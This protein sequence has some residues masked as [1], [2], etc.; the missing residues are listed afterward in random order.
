METTWSLEL[1]QSLDQ[2]L[3]SALQEAEEYA[4]AKFELLAS[5]Q[6]FFIPL[7]MKAHIILTGQ[8]YMTADEISTFLYWILEYGHYQPSEKCPFTFEQIFQEFY[9]SDLNEQQD[10]NARAYIQALIQGEQPERP[11]VGKWEKPITFLE[12]AY[13]LRRDQIENV[14]SGMIK[15]RKFPGLETLIQ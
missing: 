12:M 4:V 15:S 10:Q 9:K 13:V 3:R 11:D 8:E 6:K 1:H 2:Q 14:L 7:V 5:A